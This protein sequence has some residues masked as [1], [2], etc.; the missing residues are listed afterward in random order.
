MVFI[1]QIICLSANAQKASMTLD[2]SHYLIGDWINLSL[3]VQIDEQQKISWPL[4]EQNLGELE[5]LKVGLI[6][7]NKAENTYHQDLQLIAFDT[8]FFPIPAIKFYLTDKDNQL[9]FCNCSINSIMKKTFW[10]C[11][12]PLF[13]LSTVMHGILFIAMLI[14][15]S[16]G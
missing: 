2:S 6:D 11:Q 1:A 8:G 7:S 15:L 4:F 5:I 13:A 9:D 10:F 3:D 12:D 16:G 14:T